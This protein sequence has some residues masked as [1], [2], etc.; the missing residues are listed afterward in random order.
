MAPTPCRQSSSAQACSSPFL[1]AGL[2]LAFVTTRRHAT[3]LAAE[4]T[5][6]L[7]AANARLDQ[8]AVH[9]QHLASEATRASQA[10]TEF[11]AMMSHEIRTPLNGVIGMTGLLLDSRLDPQQRELAE[12]IRACGDVLLVLLND[13]LDLSKIEAGQLTLEHVP[14]QLQDLVDQAFD[15]VAPRAAAQ[16]LDLVAEVD[17]DVPPSLRGDPARL[18]QV[19]LN[20]LSNAVKFTEQGEVHL[21]AHARQVGH[22]GTVELHVSVRDTGIGIPPDV[23]G[24]L[25]QPFSQVDSSISRRFGGTGL[26]LAICR[27]V[28]DQ[29]NGRMWVESVPGLGSTFHFRVRLERSDTVTGEPPATDLA[30]RHV[31]VVDDNPAE[32][33]LVASLLRGWGATVTTTSSLAEHDEHA[34]GLFAGRRHRRARARRFGPRTGAAPPWDRPGLSP[35]CAHRL[36]LVSCPPG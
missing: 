8:A 18:R 27:R 32:L 25:F 5:E 35:A 16:R 15:V 3:H 31:L 11:L 22:D 17:P 1:S 13:V 34:G 23:V 20:L 10:K 24:Q 28:V 26:G 7:V 14:F 9:A 36:D 12:T 30:S 6:S 21:R 2:C 33:R 29:M 19:L 4:M